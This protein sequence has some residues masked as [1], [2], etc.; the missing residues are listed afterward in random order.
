MKSNDKAAIFGQMR[1][2]RK[3][4]AWVHTTPNLC[5]DAGFWS[6]YNGDSPRVATR[7]SAKYMALDKRLTHVERMEFLT[8]FGTTYLV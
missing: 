2:L 1:E 3:H 6:P 4:G 7:R 5:S 8:R